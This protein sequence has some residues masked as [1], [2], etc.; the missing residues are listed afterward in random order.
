[1]PEALIVSMFVLFCVFALPWV[2]FVTCCIALHCLALCQYA[3]IR[4]TLFVRSLVRPPPIL[5]DDAYNPETLVGVAV[6]ILFVATIVGVMF[7]GWS[8]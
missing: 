4:A 7:W 8:S 5:D 1:M 6:V 3:R 2:V